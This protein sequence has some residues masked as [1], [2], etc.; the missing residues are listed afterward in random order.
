MFNQ[1]TPSG[2][3]IDLGGQWGG[4]TH[5]RL[6]SL[7]DELGLQRHP[8]FFDGEGELIWNNQKVDASPADFGGESVC[9][10]NQNDLT[11][12]FETNKSSY[13]SLRNELIAISNSVL[14]A[15]PWLTPNA[16]TLDELPIWQWLSER[17]ATLFT[18]WVFVWLLRGGLGT[19]SYETFEAS[20]LHLAWC[21]AVGPQIESPESWL[22]TKGAGEV[23][24]MI[25]EELKSDIELNSP[26]QEI[27]N[28][29]N[30]IETFYGFGT[31]KALSSRAVIVAI[32][33]A[34]RQKSHLPRA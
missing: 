14:R 13:I 25:G 4:V 16:K 27:T 17:Q 18:R 5:H 15:E 22:I 7:T 10:V 19:T 20:L 2:L 34:L 3:I 12:I 23:L 32:Q 33:P 30:V 28:G 11:N 6:E 9:M 29:K 21:Q 1:I 8:S 31:N 26:V 24:K